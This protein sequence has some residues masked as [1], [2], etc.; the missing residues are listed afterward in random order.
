MADL[1]AEWESAKP[2]VLQSDWDK[3]TPVAPTVLERG[4][5]A[6]GGINR[7]IAGLLGL[8]VD[9]AENLV[10]L[11]IAGVGTAATAAGRPDLAPAPLRGSL[12]GSENI[13][14]LM[15]RFKI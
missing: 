14:K 6:L 12:G 11:G 15:E 5:A 7:G 1:A 13:A 2:V 4:K 3:A 9:T 8:P 10:N